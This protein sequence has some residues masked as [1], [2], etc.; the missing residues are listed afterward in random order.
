MNTFWAYLY[1]TV[2]Q[3]QTL[4]LCGPWRQT[5]EGCLDKTAQISWPKATLS[6]AVMQSD[7]FSVAFKLLDEASLDN[8]MAD[9]FH[10][11]FIG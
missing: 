1:R 5:Y 11:E 10:E 9:L 7:H 3:T 4:W 2:R 6:Q 8:S